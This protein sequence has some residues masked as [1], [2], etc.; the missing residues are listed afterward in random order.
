M[1]KWTNE[2]DIT[3]ID[4][5]NERAMIMIMIVHLRRCPSTYA[6]LIDNYVYTHA[7]DASFVFTSNHTCADIRACTSALPFPTM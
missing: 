2:G 3:N 4:N 5:V 6:R 7:N 1:L